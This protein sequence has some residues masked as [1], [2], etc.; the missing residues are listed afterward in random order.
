[1]SHTVTMRLPDYVYENYR[2]KAHTTNKPVKRVFEEVLCEG[3]PPAPAVDDAPEYL[4]ADLK[5]LEQLSNEELRRLAESHMEPAK[6][7]KLDRLT[8]KRDNRSLT[9]P[10]RAT[11]DLLQDEGQRLT[12]L[13]AHAWVLL[14]WRGEPVPSYDDMRLRSRSLF[15]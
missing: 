7:R 15:R 8:E 14:K 6:Q 2:H 13:K 4:R 12:V 11:L 3:Q 10:D 1:M 9:E 5:A